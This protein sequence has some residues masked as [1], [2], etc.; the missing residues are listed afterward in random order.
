MF[1]SSFFAQSDPW[2]N[3]S[4]ARGTMKW[5]ENLIPLYFLLP[6]AW[7]PPSTLV[8][9]TDDARH[10]DWVHVMEETFSVCLTQRAEQ[11]HMDFSRS[12]LTFTFIRQKEER[13][14]RDKRD[15]I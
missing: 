10:M 1:S 3:F 4:S 9:L 2:V 12:P 6:G 15:L 14:R 7:G 13:E 8:N 11:D 5:K